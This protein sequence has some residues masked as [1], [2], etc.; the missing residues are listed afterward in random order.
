MATQSSYTSMKYLAKI[1]RL[2]TFLWRNRKDQR[3]FKSVIFF[4]LSSTNQIML[5][6]IQQQH[7]DDWVGG[8]TRSPITCLSYLRESTLHRSHCSWRAWRARGKCVVGGVHSIDVAPQMWI[9]LYLSQSRGVC[10]VNGAMCHRGPQKS[11]S[12]WAS[13]WHGDLVCYQSGSG[14]LKR[15]LHFHPKNSPV[16]G[17]NP[18]YPAQSAYK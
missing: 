5:L 3:L 12:S 6:P 2:K 14:K 9:R 15:A 17:R 8:E 4:I 13:I 18:F 1:G 10:S 16:A 7:C 11:L